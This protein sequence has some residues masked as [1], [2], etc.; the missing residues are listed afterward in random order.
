[1]RRLVV[2]IIKVGI[3]AFALFVLNRNEADIQH[4]VDGHAVIMMIR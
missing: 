3:V 2:T 4:Y 1:M